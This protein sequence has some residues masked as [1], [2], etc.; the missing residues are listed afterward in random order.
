MA[1]QQ[2][3]PA[4]LGDGRAPKARIPPAA[5]PLEPLTEAEIEAAC[6]ILREKR[7]LPDTARFAL[8]LLQEPDK[9]E[10]R[11]FDAGDAIDRRAFI[12]V[13]DKA[14]G[15][16]SEAVVS[17]TYRRID[18]WEPV[19]PDSGQPS[20]LLEEL[21]AVEEIVK[22][23]PDWRA[24]VRRRGVTNIDLVQ[25]DP[26]SA[27]NF[28]FEAERGRRLV[29][30][31]AYAR[32]HPRDNGYAHPLEGLIAYV[33][34]NDKRVV[35]LVD[36][37]PVPVPLEPGN[38][39]AV[40]GLPERT[41]LKPLDIVQPEGP[42]FEI[43][44]HEI[45]WQRW[46][47]RIST[48]AREGLVLH[49]VSYDGRSILYRASIS[50]MVVPYADP[51]PGW[52]WRSAFDAGE[53][54]LGKLTDSLVLG[55]DCLGEIRYFDLVTADDEGHAA[56]IP[57]AVCLHEEDFGV[58][59]KHSDFR[60]ESH[61]V[62]RSRRLV[63]SLFANVGNYDYG[64]FWY[65][66]LD[67]SIQLE[68]KLNGIVQTAAFARGDEYPWG[69]TVAPGLAAV[70][71]QHLFN[72]RLD[73][74]VDGDRNSVHEVE[75]EQVPSGAENK[76]GNA[77]RLRETPLRTELEA[78]RTANP[79]AG[80][81]WKIVNRS[82]LNRLGDPVAY[83]LVPEGRPPLLAQPDSPFAR[84]AAFATKHLWVTKHEPRERHAAG[85]YP[86]QHPGGDGLPR[87]TEADRPIEDED[88]VV[89]HTF[90]STHVG[91]PE[92]WPVMPVEYTGFW[93]KPVGFFDRNPALDV[94][95]HTSHSCRPE[96]GDHGNG[97]HAHE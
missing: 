79:L 27:G 45:R 93:L 33:D 48:N 16:F 12:V 13:L 28:G 81:Y 21:F 29:R 1:T 63:L 49:T 59:W 32:Q 19:P 62:R 76:Y 11:A 26:F 64:F 75:V 2:T 42:S 51:G 58:L 54:G 88:V 3:A 14:D 68:V 86:N 38:Y 31:P 47:F 94:P 6:S 50:E 66:Y 20:M 78:R 90:G 37:K 30:A 69:A 22:A 84:R 82:V 65:F 60:F 7:P 44:G 56:T 77:W 24:A 53:Y 55:C 9:A 4:P 74:A 25:V 39:G 34:L 46:R 36:E 96:G 23:D 41:D 92:D 95:E 43:E 72:A 70:H 5:H 83:K 57:N 97:H 89:W 71:H 17:I 52:F 18:S 10:V 91:R 40:L 15:S 67:G 80:R 8:V 73:F 87:W 61:E 35:K 85:A